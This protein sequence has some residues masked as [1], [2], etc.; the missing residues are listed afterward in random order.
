M[1]IVNELDIT[2]HLHGPNFFNADIHLLLESSDQ[3]KT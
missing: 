2:D 1:T 3:Q